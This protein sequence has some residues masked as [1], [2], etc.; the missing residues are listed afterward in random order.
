MS[1]LKKIETKDELS[2]V[3]FMLE[4]INEWDKPLN[5]LSFSN[6]MS[7]ENS[8]L[9]I[10]N[11]GIQDFYIIF[12]CNNQLVGFIYSY[13]FRPSDLHCKVHMY[14][15]QENYSARIV[16]DF[17][18]K[19]FCEYPLLKMFVYIDDLNTKLKYGLLKNG[20]K[21]E[22]ILTDYYFIKGK[23]SDCLVLGRERND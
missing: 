12:D 15:A 14:L 10:K 8:L 19:L 9:R 21:K 22:C 20:F 5:A 4:N 11:L 3:F 18:E 7:F 23:H 2:K 16:N 17:L 13:E 1:R 6:L